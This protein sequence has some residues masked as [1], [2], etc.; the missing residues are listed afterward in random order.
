M[1]S[2]YYYFITADGP[3]LRQ[4]ERAFFWEN[5]RGQTAKA[6]MQIMIKRLRKCSSVL[7]PPLAA[8][9]SVTGCAR[10]RMQQRMFF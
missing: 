5:R 6:Q 2:V 9:A 1:V 3:G 4:A 7:L 8:A 10:M